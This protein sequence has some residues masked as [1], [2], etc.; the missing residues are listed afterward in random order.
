MSLLEGRLSVF[1]CFGMPGTM[2]G[3]W[4]WNFLEDEHNGSCWATR[5][6]H[7]PNPV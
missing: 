2:V 3:T 5:L 1:G 6:W 4:L 7:M